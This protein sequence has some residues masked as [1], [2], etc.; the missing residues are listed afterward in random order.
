MVSERRGSFRFAGH[1][2]VESGACLPAQ[3]TTAQSIPIS[4]VTRQMKTREELPEGQVHFRAQNWPS[5]RLA[6]SFPLWNWR[7]CPIVMSHAADNWVKSILTKLLAIAGSRQLCLHR[8]LLISDSHAL[9]RQLRSDCNSFCG[10]NIVKRV[11][12]LWDL[13]VLH[14]QEYSR[15]HVKDN[16]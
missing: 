16:S 12:F 7:N 15:Q 10:G 2:K 5:F 6:T 8:A 11:Q 13:M 14:C 3:S 1:Q 9:G 4:S